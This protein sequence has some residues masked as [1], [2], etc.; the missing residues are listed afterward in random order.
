MN[1]Q[2]TESDGSLTEPK[3]GGN[4]KE[5]RRRRFL[6]FLLVVLLFQVVCVYTLAARY[7]VRPEPLPDMVPGLAQLNYPP[8]YMFSIYGVDKPVGVAVSPQGDR[9]YVAET[10]GQRLVKMFNLDGKDIGSFAPPR[11]TPAQRSPVYLTADSSGRVYVADRLQHAVFLYDQTGKYM[12]T[13][14][15]PNLTLSRYVSGQLNGASTGAPYAFNQF[16]QY[17]YYQTGGAAEQTLPTPVPS[18]WAPLGVRVVK[19]GELLLTDLT[20]D[21]HTVRAIPAQWIVGPSLQGFDPPETLFGGSGQGNG[22][23][24]F[25]NTAVADSRGRIYVTDGNNA[26]ISVWDGQGRF[27]MHLGKGVGD[28]A[29]SLPRGAA[30]DSHDRLHVADAV[31]QSV[32]VYDVS[33]S[34]P[35]FLFSFG[36]WGQ[37]NG[38]FNCPNDVGLDGSGRLYVVDRENDRVQVWSY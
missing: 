34:E 31:G 20:T 30:I 10:G 25:P 3:A 2:I 16:E 29:L 11:T 14:L 28:S 38:Q 7:I 36:E 32:K 26:R 15:A 9:I 17:V 12:D 4:N 35:A 18:H 23:F 22:Q 13:I 1:T 6:L 21:H 24:L 19:G 33:K 27:L 37:G 5:K 8:H